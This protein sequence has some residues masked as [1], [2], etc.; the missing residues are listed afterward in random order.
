MDVT[1]PAATGNDDQQE[2]GTSDSGATANGVTVLET[3][4]Q[5][6]RIRH[7]LGEIDVPLD[8][9]RIVSLDPSIDTAHLISLGLSPVGATT[10]PAINGGQFPSVWGEV[11]QRVKPVGTMQ[12]PNLEAI[13]GLQP[14]LIVYNITYNEGEDYDT[15]SAIAPTVAVTIGEGLYSDLEQI[16]RIVGREDAAQAVIDAFEARL[17]ELAT[18]T[19]LA[20]KRV[21]IAT[22]F[23]AEQT[24]GLLGPRSRLG[25]ALAK[26]GA[27]IVPERVGDQ[28][29][30][31]V[32]TNLSSE[33]VAQALNSD[34][35]IL[36][37]YELGDESDRNLQAWLDSPL[38]T[39]LPAV[40]NRQF[41]VLDIQAANGN[42]GLAAMEAALE[43]LDDELAATR[44]GVAG[45]ILKDSAFE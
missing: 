34:V 17:A 20:G 40:Q 8:P 39:T 13:T 21:A 32:I 15:L 11:A 10:N 24:F 38:W 2:T 25:E 7:A 41:A 45:S 12:A 16:A 9:Q 14:D 1:P 35:I 19:K 5:Y 18:T 3:T 6:R 30:D 23:P 26:M 27:T 42:L 36:L 31:D 4:G 29:L 37:R 28:A 33:V 43:Q 22:I 44:T